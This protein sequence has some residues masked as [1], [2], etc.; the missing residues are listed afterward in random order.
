MKY[1]FIILTSLS[2]GLLYFPAIAADQLGSRNLL[3]INFGEA[4]STNSSNSAALLNYG[5]KGG[6]LLGII[7]STRV[8]F[9]VNFNHASTGQDSSVPHPN[10]DQK[11]SKLR[12]LNGNVFY[13]N[14]NLELLM[15]RMENS[16]FYLGPD[17]GL[18]IASGTFNLN[19]TNAN[20]ATSL[21]MNCAQ[22]KRVNF[23]PNPSDQSLLNA[24]ELLLDSDLKNLLSLPKL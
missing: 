7:G 15:T 13:D 5:I 3:G 22:G 12:F 2:A 17:I 21:G 8:G 14:I 10:A 24:V 1:F 16:G 4:H 18:S 23:L 6:V 19:G 11:S 9:A 20:V